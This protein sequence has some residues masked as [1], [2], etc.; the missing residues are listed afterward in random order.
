M[1]Q[2]G[3]HLV[4]HRE[5][6][7]RAAIYFLSLEE[8]RHFDEKKKKEKKD[9]AGGEGKKKDRIKNSGEGEKQLKSIV[10]KRFG[11][12]YSL[13]RLRITVGSS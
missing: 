3:I 13:Q 4:F 10:N 9:E 7:S 6:Q 12:E 2:L 11:T 1:Q 5:V 8:L